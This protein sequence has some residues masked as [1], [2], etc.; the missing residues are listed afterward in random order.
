[1]KTIKVNRYY[2]KK[3]NTYATRDEQQC[4]DIILK[5]LKLLPQPIFNDWKDEADYVMKVQS[6]E[7]QVNSQFDCNK[8]ENVFK[9][10]IN[11]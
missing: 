1:M 11:N 4:L 7:R 5:K 3:G 9:I 8:R 6:I 10:D 2:N